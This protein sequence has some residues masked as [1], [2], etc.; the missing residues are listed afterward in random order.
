MVLKFDV[1][2]DRGDGGDWPMV[3]SSFSMLAHV[4]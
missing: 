4:V 2:L 3:L 1:F